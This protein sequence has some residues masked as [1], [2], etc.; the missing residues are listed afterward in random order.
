MQTWKTPLRHPRGGHQGWQATGSTANG[1]TTP[2]LHEPS[3]SP[4]DCLWELNSAEG[5][6]K[7]KFYLEGEKCMYKTRFFLSCCRNVVEVAKFGALSAPRSC[8][9]HG[10][11]ASTSWWQLS[12]PTVWITLRR[13][14]V[15]PQLLKTT[16][17]MC[18]RMNPGLDT[19][20]YNIQYQA[21]GRLYGQ[22][23]LRWQKKYSE[24]NMATLHLF[25]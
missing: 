11:E 23:A 20:E 14:Q 24:I 9:S 17:L 8:Y 13:A 16:H 22:I 5:Q 18:C 2:L 7:V 25:F 1:S 12:P 6:C 19:W 10:R 15:S 4:G 3:C 21:V